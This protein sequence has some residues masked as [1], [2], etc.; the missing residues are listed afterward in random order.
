MPNYRYT[1]STRSRQNPQ[2]VV[3]DLDKAP[4]L[5]PKADYR[6]ADTFVRTPE[7]RMLPSGLEKLGESLQ[8]LV[9]ELDR[10][11][12]KWQ[13]QTNKEEFS[14]GGVKFD[15]EWQD[16]RDENKKSWAE[17]VQAHPEY[18]SASPWMQRG[19]RSA[20]LRT[21]AL[22]YENDIRAAWN[23]NGELK[24]SNDADVGKWSTEFRQDWIKKNIGDFDDVELFESFLP[25]MTQSEQN[26]AAT[27]SRFR[28]EETIKQRLDL[29]NSEIV[30]G[31]GQRFDK[32]SWNDPLQREG[33]LGEAGQFL[34]QVLDTATADGVSKSEANER[35]IRAAANMALHFED[36]SVMDALDHV[37]TNP[38]LGEKGTL[39]RTG[40][41]VELRT[42]VSKRVKQT[43]ESEE[44]LA[45]SRYQRGRAY[46]TDNFYAK[47]IKEIN[48]HRND[49]TW[50]MSEW[51]GTQD[52]RGVE[53]AAFSSALALHST[54][55]TS[56]NAARLDK[57]GFIE[58]RAKLIRGEISPEEYTKLA[59]S[60]A[61]SG[62]YDLDMANNALSFASTMKERRDE[63][64][65]DI[66]QA[67][68][69]SIFGYLA[70][71]GDASDGASIQL[72]NE[73]VAFHHDLLMDAVDKAKK[74]G[75]PLTKT[76]VQ[77]LS[78]ELEER[79]KQMP[80]FQSEAWR[81]FHQTDPTADPEKP[82]TIPSL[83]ERK[84]RGEQ[85]EVYSPSIAVSRAEAGEPVD[86]NSALLWTSPMSFREDLEH[87]ERTGSGVIQ[88]MAQSM[89]VDPL[90]LVKAQS[91][92]FGS[93][94]ISPG[95]RRILAQK[96][97]GEKVQAPVKQVKPSRRDEYTDPATELQ[98]YD[99]ANALGNAIGE[100]V[101]EFIEWSRMTPEQRKNAK[102]KK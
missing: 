42:E 1:M 62:A 65:V 25:A 14:Q 22:D 57:T 4:D 89:N 80:Q 55:Q 27:H 19:V 102:E 90:V 8:G 100:T 54:M 46:A 99:S 63:G 34:Q 56:Q 32:N 92:L 101:D 23:E 11:L 98:K 64:L 88:N 71:A 37:I 21:R 70:K 31:L 7:R 29:M 60:A 30:K 13:E 53:P 28:N 26:I 9:P 2:R 35:V 69:G 24:N 45:W 44:A 61:K 12:T 16:A 6:E 93:T 82:L 86:Y 39:G 40:L 95:E 83:W 76:D 49:P 3:N 97:P 15:K 48:A 85:V 51:L 18:A 47:V 74:D 68:G 33:K 84:Q 17:L 20:Y 67:S 66:V 50:N 79:V 91:G 72:A 41:A 94:Y 96:G 77:K 78:W 10:H 36:E 58:E 52:T 59:V 43:R 73:A 87:W 5:A 38:V 81:Q 75:K